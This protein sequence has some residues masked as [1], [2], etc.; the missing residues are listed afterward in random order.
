VVQCRVGGA[1]Q[2]GWCSAGCSCLAG[3]CLAWQRRATPLHH[4]RSSMA[5]LACNVECHNTTALLLQP[6]D[7]LVTHTLPPCPPPPC[8]VITVHNHPENLKLPA[9]TRHLKYQLADIESADISPL[10]GPAFEFIEQAQARKEGEQ[11]AGAATCCLL[12]P[13]AA[14]CRLR[15]H[16]S[17]CAEPTVP[18]ARPVAAA[19]QLLVLPARLLM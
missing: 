5:E 1:V 12:L 10:L 19:V 13:Y 4:V 8:R 15:P 14:Y 17:S 9:T 3:A 16:C 2:G 6:G 18:P 7:L 11:H